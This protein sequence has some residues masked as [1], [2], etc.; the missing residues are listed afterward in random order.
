[1]KKRRTRMSA[2]FRWQLFKK[3]GKDGPPSEFVVLF[4][5]VATIVEIYCE[6][7]EGGRGGIFL[8]FLSSLP[9][10]ETASILLLLWY[11]SNNFNFNLVIA[12]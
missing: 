8:L 7:S 5:C 6:G 11:S 2:N 10:E 12:E 4:F 3:I 1:M 9:E